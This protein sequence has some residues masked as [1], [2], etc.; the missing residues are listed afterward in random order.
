MHIDNARHGTPLLGFYRERDY[1]P[2]PHT[3]FWWKV[4]PDPTGHG[5]TLPETLTIHVG[6]R[7]YLLSDPDQ[8]LWREWRQKETERMQKF[9]DKYGRFPSDAMLLPDFNVRADKRTPYLPLP[10][11]EK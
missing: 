9:F 6:R 5:D 1:E 7:A 4:E 3:E 11:D 2:S 8:D 10:G